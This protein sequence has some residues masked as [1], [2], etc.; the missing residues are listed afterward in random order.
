MEVEKKLLFGINANF[1]N[2][3]FEYKNQFINQIKNKYLLNYQDFYNIIEN[4]RFYNDILNI[5]ESDSV[6][7][8]ITSKRFYE[9]LTEKNAEA[10]NIYQFKFITENEEFVDDY[11]NEY[12]KL[13]K[14]L[15]DFNFFKDLFRLKF[16]PKGIRAY[17]GSNMKILINPLYY[18]FNKDI[19]DKNKKIILEA[20]LK[21]LIVHEITNTL[22]FMKNNINPRKIPKTPREREEGEMLIN[23]LFG[24]P[25]IKNIDIFEA[26]KINNI[27]CWE[28][29]DKLRT[30]FKKK[31]FTVQKNKIFHSI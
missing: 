14:L 5:L 30:I 9:T 20:V 4:E 26:K 3:F 31:L 21:I 28:N 12:N 17:V 27:K 7:K 1:D 24:Y 22:K 8:Y 6:K 15:K 11:S 13:M 29:L 25:V 18:E 10:I 2:I 19:K 16:L 23:Y